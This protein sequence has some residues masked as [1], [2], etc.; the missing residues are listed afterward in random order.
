MAHR[1]IAVGP[2]APAS[3]ASKAIPTALNER[4]PEV[5]LGMRLLQFLEVPNDLIQPDAPNVRHVSLSV[6]CHN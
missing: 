4:V 5:D 1:A 6:G 2:P 3:T